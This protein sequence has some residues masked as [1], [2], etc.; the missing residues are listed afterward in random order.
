VLRV[1]VGVDLAELRRELLRLLA[2]SL[3]T[4]NAEAQE[5]E[6]RGGNSTWWNAMGCWHLVTSFS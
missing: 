4:R 3:H 5:N 6:K 1:E 2:R